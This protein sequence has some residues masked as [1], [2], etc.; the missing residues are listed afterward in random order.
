MNGEDSNAA[1]SPSP[2]RKKGRHMHGGKGS[3]RPDYPAERAIAL[4]KYVRY[5]VPLSLLGWRMYESFKWHEM[6][7][8]GF[9]LRFLARFPE[10]TSESRIDT[11][12]IKKTLVEMREQGVIEV[13]IGTPVKNGG[14]ATEVRRFTIAEIKERHPRDD[15]AAVLAKKLSAI[16]FEYE[17]ELIRPYWDAG[18]T[19]RVSAKRPGFQTNGELRRWKGLTRDVKPGMMMVYADIKQAEPTVIKHILKLPM[20]TDLYRL[21]MDATGYDKNKVKGMMNALAYGPYTLA[22]FAHWS[23]KAKC[24]ITLR[25]YAEHLQCYKKELFLEA[26]KSWTV[27]TLQGRLVTVLDH[28]KPIHAGRTINWRV[29]GTVADIINPICLGLFEKA[30]LVIPMHDGIYALLPVAIG[31]NYVADLIKEGA[32][33]IGM[34]VKVVTQVKYGG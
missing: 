14:V 20:D 1:A 6:A 24:D 17:G 26:R 3:K 15:D 18:I 12:N 21:L 11:K 32:R 10:L 19:G 22:Y 31:E 25:T 4:E 2:Q 13:K 9:C 7:K 23:E 30:E 27:K 5:N 28:H 34:A 16:P 29:Q 33:Q 8:S